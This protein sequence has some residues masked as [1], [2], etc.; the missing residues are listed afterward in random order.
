MILICSLF[1]RDVNFLFIYSKY[2]QTGFLLN[3]FYS[4][5]IR[6]KCLKLKYSIFFFFSLFFRVMKYNNIIRFVLLGKLLNRNNF[7]LLLRYIRGI[8]IFPIRTNYHY[9]ARLKVQQQN[10]T[11][12]MKF[13]FIV[14]HLKIKYYFVPEMY[15]FIFN[16]F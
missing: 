12:Y 4:N 8:T 2:I 9:Y 13:K 1:C 3:I 11:Y 15:Y 7:I 10:N 6:E 14:Y 5:V 16:I